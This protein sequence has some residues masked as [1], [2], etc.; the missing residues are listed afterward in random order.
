MGAVI[1]AY[2]LVIILVCFAAAM[3][4]I[5]AYAVSHRKSL[6]PQVAFFVFYI[7]EIAS[8]LGEEF[9]SQNVPFSPEMYYE[10]TMPGLRVLTGAGV[11][12]CLW[13]MLLDILDEHGRIITYAPVVLFI[14]ACAVVLV[15]LPYGAFRQ[16][17][18]YTL[19][20]VFIAFGLL[21]SLWKWI[22]STDSHYK[23][24]L[25]KR[26]VNY[27]LLWILLVFILLEDIYVILIADIPSAEND[28]LSL[29]LSSRNF[30]ENLMMLF[31]AYHSIRASL[32]ELGLRF[33]EP[34]QTN[35]GAAPSDDLL[36]HINESLPAFAATHSLSNREREVLGLLLEGLDNRRIG[37][38]LYLSE[39]TIKTH[40][41]NIMRK[42]NTRTRAEL[43]QTFWAS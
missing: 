36:R 6:L 16:W 22:S 29:Y 37:Q 41:F 30:S 20:Q 40:V 13:L 11:L 34:P 39:G 5:A 1:Y 14:I 18:F 21:Y 7:I 27:A 12:Y 31:V 17:A 10:I 25:E 4:S 33:Q 19:R 38:Q 3:L 15:G 2:T 23:S 24:R 26:K 28:W 9:V 42:T 32:K 35:E 43:K 8:I